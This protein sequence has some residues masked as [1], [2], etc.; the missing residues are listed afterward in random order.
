MCRTFLIA[1][2]FLLFSCTS[3]SEKSVKEVDQKRIQSEGHA[4]TAKLESR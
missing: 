2:A 4:V 3:S 1:I